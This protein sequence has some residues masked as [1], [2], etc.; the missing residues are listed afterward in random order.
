MM[1]LYLILNMVI[2]TVSLG[3]SKK[4][5][6]GNDKWSTTISTFFDMEVVSTILMVDINN[7]GASGNDLPYL[8]QISTMIFSGAGQGAAFDKFISQDDYMREEEVSMQNVMVLYLERK[9][10]YEIYAR[11]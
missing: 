9:M 3:A 4:W 1:P 10:G 7:D 2:K 5:R 11:L 8:Q 6:Y